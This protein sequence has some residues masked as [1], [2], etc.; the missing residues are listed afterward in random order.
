MK[1][2]AEQ[3]AIKFAKT[4]T[5]KT[6]N[7]AHQYDAGIDFYVPEF[8]AEFVD[9]L[10]TKNPQLF[11][12]P[13]TRSCCTNTSGMVSNGSIEYRYPLPMVSKVSS[14]MRALAPRYRPVSTT[15]SGR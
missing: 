2:S 1:I 5:V 11:D 9:D 13:K 15:I 12:K 3:P 10:I 4:R 8:T 7:R 6:P 14:M